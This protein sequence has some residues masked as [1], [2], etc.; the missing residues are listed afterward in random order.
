M[1]T[2]TRTPQLGTLRRVGSL[3]GK[4]YTLHQNDSD[5]EDVLDHI[6]ITDDDG[7]YL[8]LIVKMDASGTEYAEVWGTY[9][10]DL[11]TQAELIHKED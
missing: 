6:G 2:A 11:N 9:S 1:T 7:E 3:Q 8:Y 4:E 5:V 10:L